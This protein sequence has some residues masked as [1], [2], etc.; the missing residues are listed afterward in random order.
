MPQGEPSA[1]PQHIED[2]VRAIQKLHEDHHNRATFSERMAACTPGLIARPAF[3]GILTVLI[4]AWIVGNLALR[5]LGDTFFDQ[6]PFPWLEDALTLMALYM[7][8]LILITQRR[9]DMLTTHREQM[10]LQL[11]FL[12]EQKSG[13]IIALIEE[14]RRD[15]PHLEDRRDR[16][17]E[18]M[19]NP[20]DAGVVSKAL[21]KIRPDDGGAVPK[22]AVAGHR[23]DV[24]SR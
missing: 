14:M 23:E 21:E 6:P 8:V 17:A 1:L 3:V 24:N 5:S 11:A 4:A 18:A 9:A 7:A 12:S 2:T 22:A 16:E 13:K 10:T 19:A 15:S 20:V